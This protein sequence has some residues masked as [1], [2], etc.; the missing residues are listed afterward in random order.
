MLPMIS[1]A[2]DR[3]K[4][5]GSKA[6]TVADPDPPT[7]TV[8]D[9]TITDLT[10]STASATAATAAAAA[11]LAVPVCALAA[12]E[13]RPLLAVGLCHGAVYLLHAAQSSAY[14]IGLS[15][16]WRDQVHFS[17]HIVQLEL[18]TGSSLHS[19]IVIIVVAIVSVVVLLVVKA[20]TV[21][22][23]VDKAAAAAALVVAI[24]RCPAL[25]YMPMC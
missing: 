6:F 13:G 10:A 21:Q 2:T 22:A 24:V 16:V 15:T 9:A 1:I 7:A 3:A 5:C 12:C 23:V 18:C 25:A 14:E 11:R 4:L 17:A 20:V 19:M 8:T